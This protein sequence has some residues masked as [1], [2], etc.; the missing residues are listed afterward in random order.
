MSAIDTLLTLSI[1]VLG[2][3]TAVLAILGLLG[4]WLIYK[5]AHRKIEQIATQ[6]LTEYLDSDTFRVKINNQLSEAIQRR[7]QDTVIVPG[8]RPETRQDLDPNPFPEAEN[9]DDPR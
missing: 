4:W 5:S 3:F 7:L 8:L 1:W 2:I 6:S 9:Q